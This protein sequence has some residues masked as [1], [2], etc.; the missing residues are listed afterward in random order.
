MLFVSVENFRNFP[1]GGRPSKPPKPQRKVHAP[2]QKRQQKPV[3]PAPQK[4]KPAPTRSPTKDEIISAIDGD[5]FEVGAMLGKGGFGEVYTIRLTNTTYGGFE[6]A[7]K[8]FAL[9][10]KTTIEGAMDE[11]KILNSLSECD[12]IVEVY[13]I[14]LDDSARDQYGHPQNEL[15]IFMEKLAPLFERGKLNTPEQVLTCVKQIAS[16]LQ[17]AHGKKIAHSDVKPENILRDKKG[18][19]TLVDFGVSKAVHA[20]IH[21]TMGML[22]STIPVRNIPTASLFTSIRGFTPIFAAPEQFGGIVALQS[23]I[24][25]LACTYIVWIEG[26]TKL[27]ERR[28]DVDWKT[29]R[30]IEGVAVN[31]DGLEHWVIACLNP[32][33]KERPT[34][35]ELLQMLGA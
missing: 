4:P 23:D 2:A 10:N 24:F 6:I 1:M 13:A 35:T 19:A 21:V 27:E 26:A 30:L 14:D 22:N 3:S 29:L 33:H 18:N 16:A 15:W 9:P 11:F 28:R 12:N 5:Q 17:F 31:I 34:A 32:N 25:S 7:G 20:Y 8:M